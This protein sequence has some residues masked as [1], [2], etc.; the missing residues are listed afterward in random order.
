MIRSLAGAIFSADLTDAT[1]ESIRST[2]AQA[3]ATELGFKEDWLQNAVANSP[4]LV[5]SACREAGLTD[6]QWWTWTREYAVEDVGSIDVLLV[7][8][9]GRVAI[10]ETKLSYNR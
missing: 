2:Y 7:S 5:I 10:V 9:S 1:G 6:E 3:D 4:E 8:E